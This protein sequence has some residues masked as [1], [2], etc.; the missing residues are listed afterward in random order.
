MVAQSLISFVANTKAKS[1]EVNS[2]FDYLNGRIDTIGSDFSSFVKKDGSISF[3]ALESYYK[4]SISGA[5]NATPIVITSNGHNRI[6]GDVVNISGVTGN[7][8]ANGVWTITVIDSN[9]FSLNNS[10]PN[11]NYISGGTVHLLPQ[12]PEHLASKLYIDNSI[13][14]P[15]IQL[16][17]VT[18]N[19][20][21]TL[22]RDHTANFTASALATMPTT[23]SGYPRIITLDFTTNSTS[24][25]T[26]PS[27]VKWNY[28][29]TPAWSTTALNSVTFVTNNGGITWKTYYSQF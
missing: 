18:S 26:F 12:N 8:N 16:G 4:S 11:A 19:F 6:T 29:G 5:S 21:L 3:T 17:T 1:S 28:A 22:D 10:T 24:Y 14:Q 27:S 15:T 23:T 20:N 13:N 9:N 7:T 2:N 25:P